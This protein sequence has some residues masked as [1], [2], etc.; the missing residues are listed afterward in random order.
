MESGIE[1]FNTAMVPFVSIKNFKSR[2]KV[3]KSV[4]QY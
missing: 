2:K 4:F 3:T 1:N